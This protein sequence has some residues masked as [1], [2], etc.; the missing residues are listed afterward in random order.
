MKNQVVDQRNKPEKHG[1]YNSLMQ[2][3]PGAGLMLG[4][5][6]FKT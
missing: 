1:K 6:K 2:V 3:R 4:V 5:E